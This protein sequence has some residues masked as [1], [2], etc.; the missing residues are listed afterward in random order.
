MGARQ[1]GLDELMTVDDIA[2]LLKVSVNIASNIVRG[3]E[4]G[5]KRVKFPAP[6][7]GTGVRAVWLREDVFDWH[8]EYLAKQAEP[9]KKKRRSSD[10]PFKEPC[11]NHGS[12][13]S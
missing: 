8:E 11:W 9:N 12:K 6:I 7:V 4:G 5:R 13:A 2:K 3:R 1:V 10:Y